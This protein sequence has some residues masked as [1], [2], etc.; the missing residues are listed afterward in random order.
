MYSLQNK[1]IWLAGHRGMVGRALFRRLEKEGCQVIVKTRQE[2]DLADYKQ[3][4]DWVAK[5]QPDTIILAAAQVSG[6]LAN[7]LYPADHLYNNL[8]VAM[9][10]IQAAHVHN[11]EKLLYLGS[12]CIY[13]KH[14]EI[15]I[16]E[17]SLLTGVLEPTNEGY[18][19]AKITG[20]KLIEAFR[21]QHNHDFISVMPTNMYGPGDNYDPV[22]S[23]VVPALI[24]RTHQAKERGEKKIEIWGTGKPLREMLHV[25]DG[26]D[27]MVHVLKNYSAS[28]HINIGSGKDWSILEL[29]QMICETV[30]FSGKI[31]HDVTKPD[32]TPRKLM[33][34]SKLT[35]M[36]W[37]PQIDIREGL[38][39]A[40]HWYLENI[41]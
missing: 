7:D 10:V 3:T 41:V 11:V 31:T 5:N 27:A 14:A 37:K 13:P 2:L 36:G 9:N 20:L 30:G 4:E 16:V 21:R 1:K 33:D 15:P 39:D 26:A 18:A 6:I 38:Q 40:Y 34:S 32:G 17:E 8:V 35:A 23:H 25:D 12:S 29:A 28:G 24:R 19:I 22:S